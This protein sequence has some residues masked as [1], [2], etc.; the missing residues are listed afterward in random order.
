MSANCC[1]CQAKPAVGYAAL[2]P[3]YEIGLPAYG[4]R[5]PFDSGLAAHEQR[6]SALER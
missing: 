4:R 1:L 6:E 2:N 5:S 3:A